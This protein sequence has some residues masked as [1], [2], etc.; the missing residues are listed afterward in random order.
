MQDS[1]K[2]S[3]YDQRLAR[4]IL[5]PLARTALTPNQI[6]VTTLALALV[7]AWL[8]ASGETGRMAWGAGL[9]VLARFMDHLD[10]ELA[11]LTGRGSRLGYYLDYLA[12]GASYAALFLGLGIGLSKGPLEH[13]A[14]LIG[15]LGAASAVIAMLLNIDLDRQQAL[16]DGEAV[17][18]P[19]FAGSELEDGIYLLA[20]IT[21][22]GLIEPFFVAAGLGAGV[23]CLWTFWSL[24]RARLSRAGSA[25]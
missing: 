17:G 2:P 20:P 23:Y 22:L 12:G 1:P 8:L 18:Y 10:G 14:L 16:Q 19:F 6:T 5:R 21:W 4:L 15:G 9:F 7:A 13:W 24:M 25:G 3:P 11:R